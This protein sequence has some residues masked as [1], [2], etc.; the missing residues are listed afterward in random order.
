MLSTFDPHDE[1]IGCPLCRVDADTV[2]AL[3]PSQL[4]WD[5]LIAHHLAAALGKSAGKAR[6]C[7]LPAH[8]HYQL[9]PG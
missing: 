2:V 6:H 4:G 9:A 1:L 8:R 3:H 7:S 5:R